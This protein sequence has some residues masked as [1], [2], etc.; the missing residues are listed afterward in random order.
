M[1][2]F[3]K[4]FLYNSTLGIKINDEIWTYIIVGKDL[5]QGDLVSPIIINTVG[6][7]L[8]EMLEKAAQNDIIFGLLSVCQ[9]GIINLQYVDDTIPF[10]K[11]NESNARH[12]KMDF[13]LL[14][15]NVYSSFQHSIF[16]GS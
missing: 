10:L 15:T 11:K 2:E 13:M 12:L 8:S 5:K 6:Y 1:I 14:W 3:I 16:L 4:S 9:G 7:I